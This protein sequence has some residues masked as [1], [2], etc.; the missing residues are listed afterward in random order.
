MRRLRVPLG[1][2]AAV[3]GLVLFA[4]AA[5]AQTVVARWHME[6]PGVM[7]DSA[8]SHHGTT[9]AITSVPGTSGNGYSFNGTSS[10]VVVRGDV[11]DLNPGDAN[12]SFTV[13]VR[14]SE[15]PA[16]TYDLVRKGT[17]T[18]PGGYYKAEIVGAA[19][20]AARVGCHFKGS[21]GGGKRVAGG[22]LADGVWHTITCTRTATR[23]YTTIDGVAASKKVTAGTIANTSSLIIGAKTTSGGDRYKGDMD[24]VSISVG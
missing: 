21:A 12:F 3:A 24:E 11:A 13:H 14:F 23:I 19:G 1:G 18:T 15:V 9:T 8:G 4:S 2:V 10:I 20:P 16:G 5:A 6:D 7:T 22:N 17:S